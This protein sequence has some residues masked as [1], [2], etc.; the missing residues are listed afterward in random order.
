MYFWALCYQQPVA[1]KWNLCKSISKHQQGDEVLVINSGWCAV[2][3]LGNGTKK[4]GNKS[5]EQRKGDHRPKKSFEQKKN[6]SGR[7]VLHCIHLS[8]YHSS[9]LLHTTVSY[10]Y[11]CKLTAPRLLCLFLLPVSLSLSLTA[12]GTLTWQAG[13][14]G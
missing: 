10:I 9:R 1:K 3:A 7:T 14:S 2:C 12:P 6:K 13:C 4:E 11:S 5:K 8:F